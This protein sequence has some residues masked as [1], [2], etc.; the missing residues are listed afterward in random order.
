MTELTLGYLRELTKDLPDETLI[1]ESD[2][3]GA[4]LTCQIEQL[5]ISAQFLQFIPNRVHSEME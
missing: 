5:E 1:T 3:A 2:F 4:D